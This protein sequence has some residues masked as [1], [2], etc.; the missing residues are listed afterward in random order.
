MAAPPITDH[1]RN[2]VTTGQWQIVGT[3]QR[4]EVTV[5]ISQL[6]WT[7][8]GAGAGDRQSVG[9]A[10]YRPNIKEMFASEVMFSSEVMLMVQ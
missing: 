2:D 6:T 4:R 8:S 7:D 9:T 10:L 5:N 3:W 1:Q